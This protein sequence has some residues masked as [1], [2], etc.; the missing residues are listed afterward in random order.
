MKKI[1]KTTFAFVIALTVIFQLFILVSTETLAQTDPTEEEQIETILNDIEDERTAALEAQILLSLPLISDN[2]NHVITFTDPSGEG[3]YLEIDGGDYEKIENP[4]T[5]PTLGIGQHILNFKFTDD[6]DMVQVLERTFVVIPRVPQIKAPDITGAS[7][8]IGG[9]GIAAGTIELFITNGT[10]TYNKETAIDKNGIWSYTFEEEL[11]DGRYTVITLARKNGFASKY[12][13]PVI[14]E[15]DADGS[16]SNS[17]STVT[18]LDKINFK[19]SSIGSFGEI[20]QIVQDNPDL[21]ILILSVILLGFIIGFAISNS[22]KSDDTKRAEKLLKNALN[23]K[24]I[25]PKSSKKIKSSPEKSDELSLI[26]KLKKTKG[27][28]DKTI[29][30]EKSREDTKKGKKSVLPKKIAEDID[31]DNP[32]TDEESEIEEEEAVEE[33]TNASQIDNY[34]VVEEVEEI[35]QDVDDTEIVKGEE[36]SQE[37]EVEA[38]DTEKQEESDKKETETK[39]KS[40]KDDKVTGEKEKEKGGLFSF[41]SKRIKPQDTINTAKSQETIKTVEKPM[42]KEEFLSKFNKYDP[43]DAKGQEKTDAIATIESKVQ[44]EKLKKTQELNKKFA[45]SKVFTKPV[46]KEKK[47]DKPSRNIRITL[48]S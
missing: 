1:L 45:K 27:V 7:L 3:V 2:P 14:F 47:K 24:A 38:K 22:T 37:E 5:L 35:T 11:T 21:L 31:S 8:T 6:E 10:L 16:S 17:T 32:D 43:D 48:T 36:V 18:V 4:Y 19:F 20:A 13:E 26:D 12:S 34:T 23:G 39:K 30:V 9:T 15:I 44:K 41:L 42:T 29:A 28:S 46:K 33:N 25:Q 40:V